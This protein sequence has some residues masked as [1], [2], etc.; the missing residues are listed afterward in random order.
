MVTTDTKASG[1]P[2]GAVHRSGMRYGGDAPHDCRGYWCR[3]CGRREDGTF[4]PS[5]WYTVHRALGS[6]EQ[7][8]RIGLFCSLTCLMRAHRQLQAAAA[9]HAEDLGLPADDR[10]ILDSLFEQAHRQILED[11]L[12]IRDVGDMLGVPTDVL[13]SWFKSAGIAID[14]VGQVHDISAR[15]APTQTIS[16]VLR[17]RRSASPISA[18]HELAQAGYLSQPEWSHTRTGPA[19][20][21]TFSYS[22]SVRVNEGHDQVE[23]TAAGSSKRDAQTDAA[24]RLLTMLREFDLDRARGKQS[25]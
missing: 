9:H 23:A 20:R 17:T 15:S 14:H 24:D 11:G 5:G 18:L 2:Q 3:T 4:V 25:D 16:S 1:D 10:E 12:S 21:P 8:R 7:Q 13:R 6:K 19:H 22:V